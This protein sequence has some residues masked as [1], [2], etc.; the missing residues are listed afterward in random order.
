MSTRFVYILVV[1]V[2]G[3]GPGA[4][5][6]HAA[7]TEPAAAVD[8]A[9]GGAFTVDPADSRLEEVTPADHDIEVPPAP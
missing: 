7:G 4:P 8:A 5:P 6:V 9:A 3:C 1:A 2:A